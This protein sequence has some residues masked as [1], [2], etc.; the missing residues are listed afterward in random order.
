MTK[1]FFVVAADKYFDDHCLFP[2]REAAVYK[3]L[4]VEALPRFGLELVEDDLRDEAFVCWS[5]TAESEAVLL[6]EAGGMSG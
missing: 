1:S 6:I 3:Y 2:D 4:N 5:S